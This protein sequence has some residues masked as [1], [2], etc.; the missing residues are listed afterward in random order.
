M[1]LTEP[2]RRTLQLVADGK[3]YYSM[4]DWVYLSTETRKPLMAGERLERMGLIKLERGTPPLVWR[5]EVV[6]TDAG[7]DV[8]S[9]VQS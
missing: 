8:L 4:R 6:L 1:T 2:Q 5:K 9:G 3:V 7:R